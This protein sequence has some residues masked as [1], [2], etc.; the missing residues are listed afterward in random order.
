MAPLARFFLVDDE[1]A[2]NENIAPFI[3]HSGFEIITST[4]VEETPKFSKQETPEL[5][6]SIALSHKWEAKD[7]ILFW[8]RF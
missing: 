8:K 6:V 7:S 1:P 5:I 4:D 2:S 3:D